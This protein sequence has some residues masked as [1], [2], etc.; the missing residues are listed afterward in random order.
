MG[1]P[2]GHFRAIIG[3][4]EEGIIALVVAKWGGGDNENYYN[5]D[6]CNSD[7][8]WGVSLLAR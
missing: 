2:G 6:W 1:G 7:Y 5:G 3:I 8:L 4:V